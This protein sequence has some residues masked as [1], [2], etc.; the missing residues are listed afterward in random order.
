MRAEIC[1]SRGRG[2]EVEVGEQGLAQR[3]VEH[4]KSLGPQNPWMGQQEPSKGFLHA[5]L[6]MVR[7]KKG[8]IG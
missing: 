7:I 4:N 3:E 6:G 8:M 5:A 1:W 2:R